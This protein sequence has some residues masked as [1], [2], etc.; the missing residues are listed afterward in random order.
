MRGFLMI[1][2]NDELPPIEINSTSKISVAFG[3]IEPPAPLR[4]KPN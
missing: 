1:Y 3:P 4:H 2:I